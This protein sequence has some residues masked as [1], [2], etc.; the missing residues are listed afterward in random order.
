MKTFLAFLMVVST[1]LLAV[2]KPATKLIIHRDDSLLSNLSAADIEH[3][4]ARFA[5]LYAKL[6]GVVGEVV[7]QNTLFFVNVS[8]GEPLVPQLLALDTSTGLLW[9]QCVPCINCATHSSPTFNPSMSA[10]YTSLPC[11]SL[12]CRQLP[13]INGC[14]FE[15]HCRYAI[16]GDD[17]TMTEGHLATEKFTFITSDEGISDVS[18]V[19]FGCGHQNRADL[20]KRNGVLGLGPDH[21]SN[22]SLP[23]QLGSKTFSYCIGD[24]ND[25]HYD[26]NRLIIGDRAK[27]EGDSTPMEIHKGLYHLSLEGISVGEKRLNI[28]PGI[29]ERDSMG[30]G[31]VVI[32]SS[33]TVTYLVR[34]GFEPLSAEVQSLMDGLLNRVS[35]PKRDDHLCYNGDITRDLTGFPVVTFHFARG[36]EMALDVNS[37]FRQHSPNVF[38]ME[39]LVSHQMSLLGIMA[40]QSYNVGYDLNGMN[41][42]FQRIDC[43]LVDE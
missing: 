38:C 3:S 10:T 7:P 42:Y 26:Y 15:E 23:Y 41:I 1:I 2:A 13:I 43:E 17:N 5:Y 30:N 12:Y 37:L 19:V 11:K 28:R 31:G 34:G 22:I 32:D 24:I 20:G 40:Q 29:F 25:P 35:N 9:V 16:P 39:V 14:D 8:I 18:N 33:S 27:I 6:A 4:M 36:A 21:E